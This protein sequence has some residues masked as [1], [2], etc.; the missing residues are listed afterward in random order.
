MNSFTQF[1]YLCFTPSTSPFLSTPHSSNPTTPS[2]YQ[3]FWF[4]MFES[5]NDIRNQPSLSRENR[6][7]GHQIIQTI[8]SSTSS[9]PTA[10]VTGEAV[11]GVGKASKIVYSSRVEHNQPVHTRT[12]AL[13]NTQK[14]FPNFSFFYSSV[15]YVYL[16]FLN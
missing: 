12:I 6:L 3:L 1:Y 13:I 11:V 16:S 2:G 14:A 9:V 10:T 4:S 5:V 8:F 7:P 15:Q